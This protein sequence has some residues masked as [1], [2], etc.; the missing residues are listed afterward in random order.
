MFCTGFD[1]T[2]RDSY[3]T[4]LVKVFTNH[5]LEQN[6]YFTNHIERK[7]Y[8]TMTLKTAKHLNTYIIFTDIILKLFLSAVFS[9]IHFF[10]EQVLQTL[11]F[12]E[13]KIT[14]CKDGTINHSNIYLLFYLLWCQK[15]IS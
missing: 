1:L 6:P 4:I 9:I 8:K 15:I 2:T 10:I 11:F 5:S 13:P 12:M 3:F 14:Y 7:E